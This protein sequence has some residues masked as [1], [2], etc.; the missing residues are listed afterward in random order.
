MNSASVI[1][2][3]AESPELTARQQAFITDFANDRSS[4]YYT[5]TDRQKLLDH[6]REMELPLNVSAGRPHH[7][8]EQNAKELEVQIDR[9][10]APAVGS[11]NS[12]WRLITACIPQLV[13][14]GELRAAFSGIIWQHRPCEFDL[15]LVHRDT[16][17]PD[18]EKTAE[19]KSQSST[20]S[21]PEPPW[22][23]CQK[24]K[25]EHINKT[26]TDVRADTQND[27]HQHNNRVCQARGCLIVDVVCEFLGNLPCEQGCRNQQGVV[28]DPPLLP[29]GDSLALCIGIHRCGFSG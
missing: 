18:T 8:P 2:S 21:G 10:D 11:L 12:T 14:L 4:L 28:N 26:V 9:V 20:R 23:D 24:E 29:V 17:K 19:D 13:R 3:K 5:C 6:I 27:E 7:L 15:Q 16:R 1:P 22:F 25:L